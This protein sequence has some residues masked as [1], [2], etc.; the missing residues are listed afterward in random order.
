[1][2]IFINA[3]EK[4]KE[5]KKIIYSVHSRMSPRCKISNIQ[6]LLLQ[7][8]HA[9]VSE[10]EKKEQVQITKQLIRKQRNIENETTAKIN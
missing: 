6:L 9:S 8:V 7:L 2:H 10:E 5:P 3:F 4:G 1:M